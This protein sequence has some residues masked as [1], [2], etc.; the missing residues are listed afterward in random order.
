MQQASQGTQNAA[1]WPSPDPGLKPNAP[2]PKPPHA[3]PDAVE[4]AQIGSVD[5][6]EGG[7]DMGLVH[8]PIVSM[9]PTSQQQGEGAAKPKFR[10]VDDAFIHLNA[11]ER[12]NDT[13]FKYPFNELAPGQGLFI[14]VEQG[15]TTDKLMS[16][17]YKQADQYRKQASCVD[18]DENGDDIMIDTAINVKKRNEDG[19][20]QLDGDKPRLSI[21]SGFTPKLIGPTFAV[22]AVV[23][24]DEL[25]DGDKA[26][27][28]GAFIVRMS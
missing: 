9:H 11:Q 2:A 6:Q 4:H 8:A 20:V 22:K 17:L 28:D 5:K 10:I 18:H 12:L 1:G 14:E 15:S 21:K 13:E 16:E 27:A 23:K 7:K 3:N 24:D 26:E 19:T 25:A